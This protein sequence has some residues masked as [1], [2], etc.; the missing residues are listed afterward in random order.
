MQRPVS[1]IKGWPF[2]DLV[3]A[4]ADIVD[5]QSRCG[6]CGL[7][8]QDGWWVT[9]E[10]S[11]CPTCADRDTVRKQIPKEHSEGWRVTFKPVEDV[12]GMHVDSSAARNTPEG[13]LKRATVIQ[14]HR[15]S[16]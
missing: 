11:R 7:S 3:A 1:D 16:Q 12:L 15:A 10:L 8:E 4:V 9:A 5:T 13:M 2:S 6:N 14:E